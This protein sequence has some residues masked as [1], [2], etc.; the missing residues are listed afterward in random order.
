MS[1]KTLCFKCSDKKWY[2]IESNDYQ[3]VTATCDACCSHDGGFW[4]LKHFYGINNG[5]MACNLCG[6]NFTKEESNKLKYANYNN[7]N[8]TKK[9]L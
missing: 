9:P 3:S 8:T 7:P 2:S 6:R 5:K 4:E 1:D